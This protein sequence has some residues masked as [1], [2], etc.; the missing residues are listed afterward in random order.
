VIH[1]RTR[2]AAAAALPAPAP[3]PAPGLGEFLAGGEGWL[4]IVAAVWLLGSAAALSMM[5]FCG[6]RF[7]RFVR[8]ATKLDHDL[9]IRVGEL[10]AQTGVRIPPRVIVVEGVVSPML[11]GLGE[12]VCIVFPARLAQRLTPAARDSLLLHELAHFARGDHWVRLLEIAAC[13]VYWWNPV[14]WL[15]LRRIEAAEEECCDSWVIERQHGSRYSYAEAL[16][17][18]IDFLCEPPIA[19]PPTACGLGEV[20]LL[21]NRLVQI[22]HGET[23][24]RLSR[25]VQVLVL[26]AGV[27]ISPLEPAL[28]ATSTSQLDVRLM[29]NKPESPP[30]QATRPMEVEAPRSQRQAILAPPAQDSGAPIS[31]IA[32]TVGLHPPPPALWATAVSP[33][34]QYR[35]EARAGMRV[36]LVN[37]ANNYRVDLSYPA[38]TCVSFAPSSVIFASGH[39]DGDV[40][41]GD[42]ATGGWMRVLKGLKEPVTSVQISPDGQHVAAGARDGEV[43]VWSLASGDEEARLSLPD[44]PVSCLRWSQGGDSLAIAFGRW[45]DADQATLVIW[46]PDKDAIVLEEPLAAPAGALDWLEQGK[47]LVIAGWDGQAQVWNIAAESPVWS[48]QLEKN[49]VSAAAWSPD[50]PLALELLAPGS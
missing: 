32:S 17:A 41:L 46:S 44:T 27:V 14:L 45:S 18:T 31:R 47:T 35:L 37:L 3:E 34:G 38:I 1:R 7:R 16:L 8:G 28:W 40:R 21:K 33:D 30:M 50:C 42:S 2:P 26:A 10:A 23:A 9:A 11:W 43:L 25:T 39:D 15:A 4:A 29:E 22:M 48:L 20:S 6:W 5:L 24:T 49:D 36:A 19:L 13:V 12:S